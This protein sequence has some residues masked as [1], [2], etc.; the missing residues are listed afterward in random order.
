[1]SFQY[2]GVQVDKLNELWPI[3]TSNLPFKLD[4]LG[5][6]DDISYLQSII[7]TCCDHRPVNFTEYISY[8]MVAIFMELLKSPSTQLH[9]QSTQLMAH[10]FNS[11]TNAW[12]RDEKKVNWRHRQIND[13]FF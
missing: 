4:D 8:V 2:D 12:Y 1:M 6:A 13:Y 10:T 11:T 9:Q 3:I 5:N 7:R